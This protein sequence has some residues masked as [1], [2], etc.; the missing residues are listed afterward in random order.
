[1]DGLEAMSSQMKVLY[2]CSKQFDRMTESPLFDTLS[3]QKKGSSIINKI[4][5]RS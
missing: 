2:H 4:Q 1:M 3:T 5:V